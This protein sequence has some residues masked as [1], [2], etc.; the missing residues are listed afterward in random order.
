MS[1][2]TE[3]FRIKYPIIQ[4][5]MGNISNAKL[6]SAVSEAGGLGTIGAGTMS[7]EELENIVLQTKSMTQKP[8]A[9]NIAITVTPFLEEM[10]ELVIKRE[11]PVVSLSAG[12]PSPFIKRLKDSGIKVIT[13]V[14]AVRHALKA[15]AAGTDA[16]VAEGYEAAGINSNYESTTMTLIPQI[17]SRVKIPVIAA[18]G[19]ADGRGLAAAMLLGA[20]GVQIGTRLIATKEAPFSDA[21]KRRILEASDVDTVIVGRSVNRVRRVLKTK[22]AKK[23]LELENKDFSLEKFNELTSEKYHRIGAVEG[24]FEEGFINGGQISG[25]ID[26]IP[27]VEELFKR[28]IREAAQASEVLNE[29]KEYS[30]SLV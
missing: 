29:V 9:V 30:S 22:Y 2:L 21:Y 16:V 28:M 18:G 8:F 3:L 11:V 19:I 14:G 17:A 1:R 6:T 23:L 13:V 5:G 15:E 12:D 4:G 27:S 25:L 24:N 10:I 20:S 7:P 26:D